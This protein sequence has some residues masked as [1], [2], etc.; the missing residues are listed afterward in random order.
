MFSYL[1]K[2]ESHADTSEKYMSALGI[3]E[4]TQESILRQKEYEQ[5]VV[6][7]LRVHH[8]LIGAVLISAAEPN[9]PHHGSVTHEGVTYHYDTR[10]HVNT[11]EPIEGAD[12]YIVTPLPNLSRKY[13]GIAPEQHYFY[14][15][16]DEA[17]Y[18]EFV[19]KQNEEEL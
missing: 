9:N 10:F 17:T 15:F 12:D 4:E 7:V 1:Y 2:K 14:R 18:R 16:D 11:L 3:D 8:D 5:R 6:R 19:P 13:A